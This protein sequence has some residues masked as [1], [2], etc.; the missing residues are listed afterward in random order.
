VRSLRVLSGQCDGALNPRVVE[1]SDNLKLHLDNVSGE[2]QQDRLARAADPGTPGDGGPIDAAESQMRKA[3]G[4]LGESTRARPEG[5]RSESPGRMADRFSGGL[6][7]RR[8]VQDGDIPVTVLRRDQP[9]EAPPHRGVVAPAAPSTSRLQRTEAALA[10]ETAARERAERAL[11]ETQSV[12]RDL[13]TKIGHAEL[14][15]NEA[16]EAL[17]HERESMSQIRAELHACEERLREALEQGRQAERSAQASEEH[18]TEERHLRKAAE[19]ALRGAETARDAA[20]QLVRTLS[21][22]PALPRRAEPRV[23]IPAEVPEVIAPPRRG[24][25]PIEVMTAEPEPVK[26]WLN[27]RPASKRR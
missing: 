15:R 7:R 17:R 10:A 20:E 2:S 27:T 6:H 25:P 21:E 22:E 24:R 8:F 13:Q 19:K 4:L 12:V 9:H 18:L 3:L 5:D 23:R 26:W 16:V 11:H 1:L 14:A